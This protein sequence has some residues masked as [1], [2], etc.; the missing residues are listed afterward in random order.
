MNFIKPLDHW[1]IPSPM[2]KK[3][4]KN[5]AERVATQAPSSDPFDYIIN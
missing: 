2:K 5:Q 1:H 3:E 4:K